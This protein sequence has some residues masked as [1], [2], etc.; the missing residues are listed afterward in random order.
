MH[1]ASP[2][3]GSHG[4]RGSHTAACE[5]RRLKRVLEFSMVEFSMLKKKGTQEGRHTVG[6]ES[7]LGED[8]SIHL[9]G[10]F[11]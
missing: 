1:T 8:I 9:V 2:T 3:G 7:G 4:S 5:G 11:Q 6:R 10:K